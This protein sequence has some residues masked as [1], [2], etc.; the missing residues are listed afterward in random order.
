M[1]AKG[2]LVHMVALNHLLASCV[3]VSEVDKR[4]YPAWKAI[5]I[6]IAAGALSHLMMDA[7]PHL[8]P[9]ALF[10]TESFTRFTN[11]WWFAVADNIIGFS[12]VLLWWLKQEQPA[13]WWLV[14]AAIVGCW[15]PDVL[16]SAYDAGY[17]PKWNIV[18]RAE[19]VHDMWH[20][21][22]MMYWSPALKRAELIKLT[23]GT[24]LSLVTAAILVRRLQR[25]RNPDKERSMPAVPAID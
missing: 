10:P 23:L 21:F 11:V 24:V 16:V 7:L 25:Q 17:T 8:D 14:T 13:P 22:W 6:A 18:I 20:N 12:I 2:G 3:L 1:N 5:L 9:S 4:K 15:G 19:Q